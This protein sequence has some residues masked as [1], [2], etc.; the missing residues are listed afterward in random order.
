MDSP[1]YPHGRSV[2]ESEVARSSSRRLRELLSS[3]RAPPLFISSANGSEA[4]EILESL[5]GVILEILDVL[6]S[7]GG[8][9]VV[10]KDSELT[11]QQAADILN[12]S[13]PYLI[14]LLESGDIPFH[15]V[16]THRRVRFDE[17]YRYKCK[18]D[19]ARRRVLDELIAD[20]QELD[21]GY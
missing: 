8:V 18:N 2:T 6:S 16:G 14:E 20:A 7:T 3:G 13:R 4:I 1:T 19:A 11:T 10:C 5:G 9:A 15:T 21:M 12:V 17:V